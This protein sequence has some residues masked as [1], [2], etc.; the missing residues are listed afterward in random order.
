MSES[1]IDKQKSQKNRE[2]QEE[3]GSLKQTQ[4]GVHGLQI[5]REASAGSVGGRSWSSSSSMKYCAGALESEPS[6]WLWSD[7]MPIFAS[8]VSEGPPESE[9]LAVEGLEGRSGESTTERSFCMC[10]KRSSSQW[11]RSSRT[12]FWRPSSSF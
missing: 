2:K 4:S 7:R 1:R 5:T 3:E 12:C 10:C 6:S 11:Q 9:L 8:G